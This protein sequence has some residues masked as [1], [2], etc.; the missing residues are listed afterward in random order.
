MDLFLPAS[1]TNAE[2]LVALG[3]GPDRI[4]VV[5]PFHRIDDLVD[6]V[7]DE[8]ALR[9]WT[10]GPTTAL[11]V[12]RVAPN[13]GHRR[14]LRVAAVFAELFGEALRVRF[15]GAQD[16]RLGSWQ[17]VLERD[18]RR[19]GVE[20]M[21]EFLGK[22]TEAELKAAYLTSHVF[23]CCSEHEGFCVPLVEAG[24]LGCPVV[25]IHQPAIAETL[26][27][28]GL[29]L[30]E[31]SDEVIAAAVRR[32]TVDAGVRERLVAGLRSEVLTRFSTKRIRQEFLDAVEP[33]AAG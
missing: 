2:E 18:A 6:L 25:A 20:G 12:G 30:V 19:F 7:P 31:P 10:G 28:S 33:L 3:A 9:R 5:P 14:I 26:G 29:V 8:A 4:A 11:F 23:L 13:K 24:H 15:V 17:R 32:V 1:R 22:R 27:R 21:V 16:P